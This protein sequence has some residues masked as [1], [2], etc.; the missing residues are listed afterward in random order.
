[1]G[2]GESQHGP[3]GRLGIKPG[4]FARSGRS[5]ALWDT[6]PRGPGA[7]PSMGNSRSPGLP[8]SGG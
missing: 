3:C 4:R 5:T 1:M 8:T 2:L 6:A 7:R